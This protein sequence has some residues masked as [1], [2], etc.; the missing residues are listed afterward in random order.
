MTP[1]HHQCFD[2]YR[3]IAPGEMY[4]FQTNVY[5]GTVY[6]IAQHLDCR[7]LAD[8]YRT[9]ARLS[10]YDYDGD[11]LP[12]LKD[13]WCDSGEHD[14][15]CDQYRGLYPHAVCRMEWIEQIAD[16]RLSDRLA[17]ITGDSNG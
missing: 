8:H 4:A 15:L 6:T 3:S 10:L 7:D 5:D 11:G 14:A 2:C 17:A 12:P 1:K 13:D 16:F 9:D